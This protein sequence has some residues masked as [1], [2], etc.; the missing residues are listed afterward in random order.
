M[1][2]KAVALNDHARKHR[3]IDSTII[4]GNLCL[5]Q[6]SIGTTWQIQAQNKIVFLEEVGE[7][8]YRTDRMLEHL[9]QAAIFKD[10]AAIIFGDFIEDKEPNGSSLTMQVLEKFADSS[11]LPVIKMNGIGHGNTNI[12]LPLGTRAL[13]RL[14]E[15][16]NLS[17]LR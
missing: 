8:G 17:V 3:V 2:F 11:P 4:G 5:V 7:R 16:L 13:L 9:T 15:N 1:D 6:T 14:G 10:A 12:P